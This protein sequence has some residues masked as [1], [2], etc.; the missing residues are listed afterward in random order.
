MKLLIDVDSDIILLL[1]S[2]IHYHCRRY[3]IEIQNLLKQTPAN[4]LTA[5]SGAEQS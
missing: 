1:I 4:N 2:V 3:E 5:S